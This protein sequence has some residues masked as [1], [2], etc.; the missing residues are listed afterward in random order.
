[1]SVEERVKKVEEELERIKK[2]LGKR[3]AKR[4]VTLKDKFAMHDHAQ[5][6][7]RWFEEM[8]N[9]LHSTVKPEH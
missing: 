5:S 6:L 3:A 4:K 8:E 2:R 1:M 7:V 9:D